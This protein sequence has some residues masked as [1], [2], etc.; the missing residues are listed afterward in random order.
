MRSTF[1]LN[2]RKRLFAVLAKPAWI[3]NRKESQNAVR[4]FNVGSKHRWRK[5]VRVSFDASHNC[6]YTS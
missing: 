5:S 3:H 1:P 4:V 2:S 6:T